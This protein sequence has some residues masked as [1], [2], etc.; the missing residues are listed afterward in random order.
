MIPYFKPLS[1]DPLIGIH[2]GDNALAKLAHLNFLVDEINTLE[3]SLVAIDSGVTA[4]TTQTN[5][6]AT[7][8]SGN[9]VTVSTSATAQNGIKLPEAT[10]GATIKVFNNG[11]F[12]IAVYPT[13]GEKFNSLTVAAGSD[14]PNTAGASVVSVLPGASA[15]FSSV[16]DGTWLFAENEGKIFTKSITLTNAQILALNTTPI[17]VVPATGKTKEAI[18]P[19][20]A[21]MSYTYSTAAYATNTQLDLIHAGGSVAAMSTDISQSASTVASFVPY[22]DSTPASGNNL[23]ANAALTAKVA[24]GD[25]TGGNA[26]A[27]IKVTVSYVVLPILA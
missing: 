14:T 7:L 3:D 16:V 11:A 9:I 19:L 21:V 26:G 27:S 25:P 17:T 1:P 18:V 10:A 13:V 15:E 5:T 4:G 24:T 6:G 2:P 23:V 8:V 20:S 22:S 12:A